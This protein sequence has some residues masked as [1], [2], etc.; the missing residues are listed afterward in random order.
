MTFICAS[1]HFTL[2]GSIGTAK[3]VVP[4]SNSKAFHDEYTIYCN[5]VQALINQQASLSTFKRA[6]QYAY[7]NH[8]IRMMNCKGAINTCEICN[9]A[10][11]LL[12]NSKFSYLLLSLNTT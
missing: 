12:R 3:F 1:C 10:S 5:N 7:A 2:L 6:Y 9:N 11:D 8:G 4:Y